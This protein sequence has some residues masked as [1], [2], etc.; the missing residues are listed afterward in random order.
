MQGFAVALFQLTGALSG[1]IFT[2]LLGVIGDIYEVDKYPERYGI[3]LTAFV[4]IS[5]L[6]C[7]PF[8]LCNA[9]EYAQNIKYQKII[10]LYVAKN[11]KRKIEMEVVK[12]KEG[13]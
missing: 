2:Y 7:I 12:V 10:T 5:Y 11:S 13:I 4:L 8:F 9:R 6:G 1:S 3:I